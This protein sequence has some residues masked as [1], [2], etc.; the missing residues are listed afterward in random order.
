[1][2]QPDNKPGAYY[3]SVVDGPRVGRLL[4]PFINNHAGALTMVEAARK[5]AEECDPRAVFYA[6]GTIREDVK[7]FEGVPM[8]RSGSLNKFFPDLNI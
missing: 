2:Q 3:V 5:K 1:M 4:G 7:L 8:N 6:Y